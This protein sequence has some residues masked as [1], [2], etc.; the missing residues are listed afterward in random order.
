MNNLT[1]RDSTPAE[2]SK[3]APL[4]AVVNSDHPA[5]A[6]CGRPLPPKFVGLEVLESYEDWHGESCKIRERCLLFFYCS[7]YCQEGRVC[8]GPDDDCAPIPWSAEDVRELLDHPERLDGVLDWANFTR[9]LEDAIAT[10][11]EEEQG[12]A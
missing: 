5:C 3:Q 12:T 6:H 11:Q 10:E 9:V 8:E 1:D 2:E 7:S 4:W